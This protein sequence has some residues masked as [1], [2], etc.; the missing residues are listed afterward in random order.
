MGCS[1]SER[2]PTGRPIWPED[3]E[4]TDTMQVDVT[5]ALHPSDLRAGLAGVGR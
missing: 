5:W 3:I 1:P 2:Q 4:L